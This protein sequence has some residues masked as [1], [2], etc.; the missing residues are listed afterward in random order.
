MKQIVDFIKKIIQLNDLYCKNQA[1]ISNKYSCENNIILFEYY[2]KFI[3]FGMSVG[4]QK[5]YCGFNT[6][7]PQI[8]K[9]RFI[10][11]HHL[12][13]PQILF[14]G[15]ESVYKI[16]TVI[17]Q[18]QISRINYRMLP[19]SSNIL[20]D[21][22]C[23]DKEEL[24]IWYKMIINNGGFLDKPMNIIQLD[25]LRESIIKNT[26]VQQVIYDLGEFDY[27]CSK[28]KI[29]KKINHFLHTFYSK[30]ITRIQR[31]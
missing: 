5:I 2:D 23:I 15:E 4:F 31:R 24:T 30:M 22:S 12:A 26:I 21:I 7:I 8:L 14:H 29:N 6:Y 27:P 18:K 13:L 1:I 19:P 10:T 9:D 28:N 16:F 11:S 17:N 25:I 20:R 3:N